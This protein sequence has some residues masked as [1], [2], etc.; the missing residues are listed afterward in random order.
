MINFAMGFDARSQGA[1]RA[2]ENFDVLLM[3]PAVQAILSRSAD[4]ITLAAVA[5]TWARFMNP[6]GYLA[7]TIHPVAESPYAIV[8]G[9]DAPYGHR[10]EF[11][12]K[13]PDSLGR[14]FPNDPAAYY[15]TDARDSSIPGVVAIAVEEMQGA[16]GRLAAW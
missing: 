16:I 4:L 15:L 2:L 13:G 10:R 11:S 9:V 14:Y 8:V 7:S 1:I 3:T 12:F 6:S 5:N